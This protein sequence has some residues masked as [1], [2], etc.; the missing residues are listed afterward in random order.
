MKWT[1]FTMIATS[2]WSACIRNDGNINGKKYHVNSTLAV[3]F[4]TSSNI[5]I[6][7]YLEPPY[8]NSVEN[9]IA[10]KHLFVQDDIGQRKADL[11]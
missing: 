3:H 9:T 6:N 7:S 5:S 8:G 2:V 4:D 1:C 10:I 11:W